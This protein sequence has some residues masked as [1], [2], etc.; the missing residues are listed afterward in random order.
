MS[1]KE[2]V[3]RTKSNNYKYASWLIESFKYNGYKVKIVLDKPLIAYNCGV[4]EIQDKK[5]VID[6]CD[7]AFRIYD[8]IKD[9]D[10]YFKANL[11]TELIN[12]EV[13]RGYDK[14]N[15]KIKPW[16][17]GRVVKYDSL[18]LLL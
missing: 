12:G 5:I 13:L 18:F 15:S 7:S 4:L 16:V 10:L 3:F 1:K 2:I 11:S 14:Y 17:L 9:C 6:W 8:E